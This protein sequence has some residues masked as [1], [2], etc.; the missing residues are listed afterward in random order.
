MK[1]RNYVLTIAVILA[2]LVIIVIGIREFG[3]SRRTAQIERGQYLVDLGGCNLCHTPKIMTPSGR[4]LDQSRLL[5]GHPQGAEDSEVNAEVLDD[6]GEVIQSNFH[7]TRWSGPWGISFAANLTPDESTGI[8]SWTEESF[9]KTIRTGRH[10]GSGRKIQMP[11]PVDIFAQF[12]DEDLEAIFAY[13]KS[14]KPVKN[15]VP[16][17]VLPA[18]EDSEPEIK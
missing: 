8:G 6:E 14:L 18:G 16:P 1:G 4:E 15:E 11:M 17:P 3:A 10:M 12:T 7:L 5:S 13:L 9:I 2:V